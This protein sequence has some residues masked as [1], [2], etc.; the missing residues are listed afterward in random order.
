VWLT[1]AVVS[2]VGDVASYFAFN[3]GGFGTWRPGCWLVLSSIGLPRTVLLLVVDATGDRL[4]ARRV[5]I[6]GDTIMM[7][8][9]AVLA[10]VSWHWGTPLALLDRAAWGT[11]LTQLNPMDLT[12]H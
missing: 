6:T 12:H 11:P 3:L 1:G 8:V 5:M 9:A 7:V 10:A 2:Q 4:G